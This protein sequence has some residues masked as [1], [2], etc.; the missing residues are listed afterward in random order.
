MIIIKYKYTNRTSCFNLPKGNNLKPGDLIFVKVLGKERLGQVMFTD[1]K[2]DNLVPELKLKSVRRPS[3]RELDLLKIVEKKKKF[4]KSVFLRK[5]IKYKLNL[6]LVDIKYHLVKNHVTFLIK[7]TKKDVNLKN[8]KNDLTVVLKANVDF[9]QL[10]SREETK[11]M[12]G[13]GSCG[14]QLCCAGF[15]KGFQF[16]SIKMVKDQ[17]LPMNPSRISGVCGKLLCCIKYEDNHYKDDSIVKL[18]IDPGL[19]VE[20]CK[21][22]DVSKKNDLPIF[23]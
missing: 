2:I 22:K 15:L 4:F 6:K 9:K 5:N 3:K 23:Y 13:I 18:K 1:G 10:S 16:I 11:R 20:K 7:S 8:I 19:L 14:R 17:N 21:Q 12:G